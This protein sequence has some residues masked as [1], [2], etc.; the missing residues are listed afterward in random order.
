MLPD[1]T[2]FDSWLQSVAEKS[3]KGDKSIQDRVFMEISVDGK[4]IGR[5]EFLLF[6]DVPR[7]AK[8]FKCLC[9]GE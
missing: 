9:T 1:P 8:N 2:E 6:L 3:I 5:I 4:D 7:T